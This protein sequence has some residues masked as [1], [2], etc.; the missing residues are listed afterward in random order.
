MC[1]IPTSATL[2]SL[3]LSV[4][5]FWPLADLSLFIRL[6]HLTLILCSDLYHGRSHVGLRLSHNLPSSISIFKLHIH[7]W[8]NHL[9]PWRTASALAQVL[10]AFEIG[11]LLNLRR[12][13]VSVIC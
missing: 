8:Y 7:E 6:E 11:I 3:V 10:R 4:S 12:I 1:I 5:L 2:R 13:V 9:D